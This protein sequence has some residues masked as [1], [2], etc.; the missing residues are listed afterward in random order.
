MCLNYW[1]VFPDHDDRE[2]SG[3]YDADSA[4]GDGD[5]LLD[6]ETMERG[7]YRSR[8]ATRPGARQSDRARERGQ[9]PAGIS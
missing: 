8:A 3:D 4:I 9:I 5:Y 1:G 6:P 2:A 7:R